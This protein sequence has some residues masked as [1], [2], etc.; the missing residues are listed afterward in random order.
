MPKDTNVDWL[1]I[2]N[3]MRIGAVALKKDIVAFEQLAPEAWWK[4]LTEVM[5]L[6]WWCEQLLKQLEP[7]D[8]VEQMKREGVITLELFAAETIFDQVPR[9]NYVKR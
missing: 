9:N 2:R 4:A 8:R 5:R 7:P 6:K 1:R 3:N